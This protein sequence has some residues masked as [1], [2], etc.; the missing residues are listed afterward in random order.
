MAK[1]SNFD[2]HC[3]LWITLK[4]IV[5]VLIFCFF[6]WPFFTDLNS[7]AGKQA[8]PQQT[9]DKNLK[10]K[11][12]L[13]VKKQPP[14]K[15]SESLLMSIVNPRDWNLKNLDEINYVKITIVH[16]QNGDRLVVNKISEEV[17]R[18]VY[19]VHPRSR[20]PEVKGNVFFLEWSPLGNM[21]NLNGYYGPFFKSPGWA[22]V[23]LQ[24]SQ[25]E[26]YLDFSFRIKPDPS[27][28]GYA[29]FWVHFFNYK[30]PPQERVYLNASAF[31]YIRFRIR[32][33]S[34]GVKL[35]IAI[36]DAEWEKRQDAVAMGELSQFLRH[37]QLTSQ[38]QEAW[39]PLTSPKI[40]S[41]ELAS[42][43]FLVEGE[44][45][46]RVAIKDIVFTREKKI[47]LK[48]RSK[49]KKNYF[50]TSKKW[51]KATWVWHQ[52][53]IEWLRD[54]NQLQK[55]IEFLKAQGFSEIFL[56]VPYFYQGK[57]GAWQVTWPVDFY[58]Y[59]NIKPDDPLFTRYQ[60]N[61][62]QEWILRW[63]GDR[64][65]PLLEKFSMAGIRVKALAGRPEH[66]LSSWHGMNLALLEAI[67]IY[68]QEHPS[69][70][71][72]HGIH[73]DIEPYLIPG[74]F[75]SRK[76][77]ILKQY[78]NFLLMNKK[79]IQELALQSEFPLGVDIP[80]WYDSRD[81]YFQ[82]IA[83]VEGQTFDQTIINIVDEIVVMDYRTMAY[84]ADGLIEHIKNELEY[85]TRRKKQIWLG[86]ETSFLPDETLYEFSPQ[87]QGESSLIIEDRGEK[88]L[89]FWQ[90]KALLL[91]REGSFPRIVLR[92]REREEVPASKV[93][94]FS[95]P[96]AVFNQ[97][98]GQALE[99]LASFPSL[100]GVAIHSFSSYKNYVS[101][102]LKE[103]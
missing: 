52:Q 45:E 11:N 5:F 101:Q 28:G 30:L 20:V 49:E 100:V 32:G 88:W 64:F 60:S 89:F 31:K 81:K 71:R 74:F 73:Y 66:A 18:I 57:N 3:F 91:R 87:G 41:Q 1:V 84:G 15:A 12:G 14:I 50:H 77:S 93:S 51:R 78:A 8:W 9:R 10:S 46:G 76:L 44:G 67:H 72:F 22:K 99:K 42:L 95:H 86:V 53:V 19:P 61:R 13:G 36:A 83:V 63:P 16:E 92:E 85:A 43:V 47:D 102:N 37:R 40:N 23:A 56:Q 82:P 26:P 25:D 2:E 65:A 79:I 70:E 34:K 103:H 55:D 98:V 59:L 33:R 7:A 69:Q 80:F 6:L 27:G 58:P 4:L 94:F 96:L 68:N 54:E 17:P 97:E 35:K 38:W 24:S 39:I 75:S 48:A 21:N 29:G 62:F 90:E